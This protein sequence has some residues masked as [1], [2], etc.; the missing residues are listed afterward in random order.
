VV[1]LCSSPFAVMTGQTIAM[2]GGW[3]LPVGRATPVIGKAV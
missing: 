3:S 2:D 1:L